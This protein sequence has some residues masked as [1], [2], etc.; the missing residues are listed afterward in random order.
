MADHEDVDDIQDSEYTEKVRQAI[1]RFRE[2]LNIM[3][4]QLQDGERAYKRLFSACSPDDLKT[5]K[6]K[7]LQWQA[8]QQIITDLTPL[9]R[10]VMNMRY[11]ARQMEI[12]FEELYNNIA[13]GP[14][15]GSEG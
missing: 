11:E 5:M 10:A 13:P 2:L 12:G 4:D 6:E 9:R 8:A 14:A 3:Q 15:P 1:M 7:D